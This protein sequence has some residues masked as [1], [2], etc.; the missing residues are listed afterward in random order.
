MKFIISSLIIIGTLFFSTCT[1]P[2]FNDLGGTDTF[3]G[4]LLLKDTL[5]GSN[6]Y[7]V[8][9]NTSVYL[10][11]PKDSISSLYSA[12]SDNAGY[13]TF[14]GIDKKAA[15]LL[16]A[17]Y[18]SNQIRYN[19][20]FLHKADDLQFM[21]QRDSLVLGPDTLSQNILHLIVK[22]GSGAPIRNITV[23]VF[24][25]P[26]L[27]RLDTVEGKAFDMIT[28]TGGVD[29]RF[30]IAA[31]WYYFRV[32][33]KIGQTILRA[34]DSIKAGAAGIWTK[35]LSLNTNTVPSIGMEVMVNDKFQT[36]VDNVIL[37]FYRSKDVFDK[38]PA[39]YA[40]SLFTAKTNAAGFAGIYLIDPAIYYIRAIK[41]LSSTVTLKGQGQIEV[42]N[43]VVPVPILIE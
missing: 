37:Y 25:S 9:R 19:A 43:K 28:N 30:G 31:G 14:T 20:L 34:E 2:P 13:F 32:N 4:M 3:S 22:D 33:A 38:D 16:T 40:N 1:R 23:H 18:D 29:N 24:N 39:P 26:E 11:N 17:S 6:A 36:P 10:R 8:M 21:N 35:V 42:T 15:Y 41:I 5:Y 7:R 27:F 12:K